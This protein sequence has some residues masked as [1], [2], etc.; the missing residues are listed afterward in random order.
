MTSPPGNDSTPVTPIPPRPAHE[1]FTAERPDGDQDGPLTILTAHNERDFARRFSFG[2]FAASTLIMGATTIGYI[3]GMTALATRL[4]HML[5]G[6]YTPGNGNELFLLITGLIIG[7]VVA[8]LSYLILG[9]PHVRKITSQLRD[10]TLR[11]TIILTPTLACAYYIASPLV[12]LF[13]E[14]WQSFVAIA[15][16]AGLLLLARWIKSWLDMLGIFAAPRTAVSATPALMV[17]RDTGEP[18]ADAEDS[19]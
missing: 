14:S 4:W 13:P 6:T 5:G 9:Q 10:M 16:A 19:P 11:F 7:G 15:P 18:Q 2:R 8:A 12:R 1:T 3:H 17:L